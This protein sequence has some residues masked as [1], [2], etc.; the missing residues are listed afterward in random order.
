M[1]L[2]MLAVFVLLSSSVLFTIGFTLTPVNHATGEETT[3][4]IV[5]EI[6]V[7]T[8]EE[9]V[10]EENVEI[11][12][13]DYF[14]IPR[15]DDWLCF[16]YATA[17]MEENPEYGIL[18]ITSPDN[19]YFDIINDDINTNHAVNY[20]FNDD[21]SLTYHD[22][23]YYGHYNYVGWQYT[24][25]NWYFAPEGFENSWD[26]LLDNKQEIYNEL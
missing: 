21:K 5:E 14:T 19:K 18:I 4:Q 3:V 7:E 10:V 15:N 9:I 6:V 22:E 16:D 12:E 13:P 11:E 26:Y 2:K 8:I 24:L 25:D 23:M 17:Y 20:K 1:N